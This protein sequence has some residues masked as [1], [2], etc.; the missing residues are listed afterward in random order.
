MCHDDDDDDQCPLS[1]FEWD[2]SFDIKVSISSMMTIHLLQRAPLNMNCITTVDFINGNELIPTFEQLISGGI[3]DG[4]RCSL[5]VALAPSLCNRQTHDDFER[6]WRVL[7]ICLWVVCALFVFCPQFS[8]RG[9]NSRERAFIWSLIDESGAQ[10]WQANCIVS[11]RLYHVSCGYYL[12]PLA[13]GQRKL[14]TKP[15]QLTTLIRA[16]ARKGDTAIGLKPTHSTHTNTLWRSRLGAITSLAPNRQA[17]GNI[18]DARYRNYNP[19]A[20]THTFINSSN[21]LMVVEWSVGRMMLL[22]V[23]WPLRMAP[24]F[25]CFKLCLEKESCW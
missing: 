13:T 11:G 14:L 9:L 22:H 8:W 15:N 5:V 17:T 21:W 12:L 4:Y 25:V 19:F 16:L 24:S 1:W 2:Y 23:W 20:H 3:S 18:S 7:S 6:Q 10:T